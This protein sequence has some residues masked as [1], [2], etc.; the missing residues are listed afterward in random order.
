MR[1][2]EEILLSALE[3]KLWF[4]VRSSNNVLNA[5]F[6]WTAPDGSRRGMTFFQPYAGTLLKLIIDIH[7]MSNSQRENEL[8]HVRA[9]M[10]KGEEFLN[11]M[12]CAIPGIA[13]PV[14]QCGCGESL[15]AE[16]KS[17]WKCGSSKP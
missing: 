7:L 4:E 5:D 17:C 11:D 3:G 13:G 10:L 2:P 1:S 14:W 9:K 8:Q 12:L 6:R 16:E 15:R